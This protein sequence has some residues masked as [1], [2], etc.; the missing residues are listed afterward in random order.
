LAAQYSPFA[1]S[2]SSEVGDMKINISRATNDTQSICG[3]KP[4]PWH[5]SACFWGKLTA[6]KATM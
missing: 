4:A 5:C 3:L 1:I 2:S 6:S